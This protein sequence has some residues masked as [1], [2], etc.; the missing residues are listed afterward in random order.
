MFVRVPLVFE[1]FSE[2]VGRAFKMFTHNM[3]S[4]RSYFP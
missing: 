2:L 1:F 3:Y 4:T